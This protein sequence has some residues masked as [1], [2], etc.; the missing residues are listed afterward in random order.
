MRNVDS[1]SYQGKIVWNR[2]SSELCF[3]YDNRGR[4]ILDSMFMINAANEIFVRYLLGVLNSNISR[5]W[6]RQNAATLGEG[7][8]GAKIYIEK[9]PIPKI[10]ESNQTLCDEIMALVDR[11]LEVKAKDSTTD[12]SELES[13]ID[14]LVYNLYNLT[15][16]E[17]QNIKA[18]NKCL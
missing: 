11:I 3:S 17:I 13:K 14:K 6:I 18:I 4:F 12:T 1:L 10:T 16:E 7:I 5:H 8:Y 15:K 2:I 9:L